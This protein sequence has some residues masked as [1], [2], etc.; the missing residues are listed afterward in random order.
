MTPSM[1]LEDSALWTMA[2]SR[3]ALRA[4]GAWFVNDSCFPL[5]S[6]TSLSSHTVLMGIAWRRKRWL[7]KEFIACRRRPP[8]RPG[9]HGL[10]R[11]ERGRCAGIVDPR[12]QADVNPAPRSAPGTGNSERPSH[13]RVLRLRYATLRMNGELRSLRSGRT[14][15]LRYATL[16]MDGGLRYAQD[17]RDNRS[18]SRC[19]CSGFPCTDS[20]CTGTVAGLRNDRAI[21]RGGGRFPQGAATAPCG[22]DRAGA[23]LPRGITEGLAERRRT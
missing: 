19:R 5:N 21:M 14:G 15:G 6:A 10:S 3:S 16:K 1:R 13:K 18:G 4:W 20:G 7:R 2:A 22:S 8:V 11:P 12:R 23:G 17:E 9:H